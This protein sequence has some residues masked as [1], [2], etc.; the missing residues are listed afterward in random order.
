MSTPVALGVGTAAVAA[1]ASTAAAERLPPVA[2]AALLQRR[3]QSAARARVSQVN[4]TRCVGTD[5]NRIIAMRDRSVELSE[6]LVSR[7]SCGDGPRRCAIAGV[8]RAGGTL[9]RHQPHTLP[10][11]GVLLRCA[12]RIS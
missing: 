9:K 12:A 2:A 10:S 11:N 6:A 4:G 5:M 1:P 3:R 7:A 8:M